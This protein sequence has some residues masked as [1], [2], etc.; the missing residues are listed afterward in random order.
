MIPLL[1]FAFV[2]VTA[3]VNRRPIPHTPIA[4][5]SLNARSHHSVYLVVNFCFGLNLSCSHPARHPLPIHSFIH[6]RSL[7]HSDCVRERALLLCLAH[8]PND[9]NDNGFFYTLLLSNSYLTRFSHSVSLIHSLARSFAHPLDLYTYYLF[10]CVLSRYNTFIYSH[11][12]RTKHTHSLA[13]IW[14]CEKLSNGVLLWLWFQRFSLSRFVRS[15]FL[16]S[17]FFFFFS[18]PLWSVCVLR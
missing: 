15:F 12:H 4:H 7:W 13:H 5:S 17:F 8:L 11:L 14:Y 3:T 10:L 9:D 18:L 6:C 16:F 1:E 2:F